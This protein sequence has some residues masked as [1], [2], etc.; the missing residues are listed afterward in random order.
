M[1]GGGLSGETVTR[2]NVA[3]IEVASGDPLAFWLANNASNSACSSASRPL[4]AAAS[5]AFM[6]GP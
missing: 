3:G 5:N 6:V 2:R 4:A 1:P